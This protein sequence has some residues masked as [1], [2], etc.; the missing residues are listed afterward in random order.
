MSVCD[1]RLPVKIILSS[2][3][4]F[5]LIYYQKNE[6]NYMKRYKNCNRNDQKIKSK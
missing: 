1:S 3:D 4:V 2:E 5:K 6:F